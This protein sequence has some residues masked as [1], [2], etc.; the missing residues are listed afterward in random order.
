MDQY[1][2]IIIGGGPAGLACGLYLAR[3]RMK[4]LLIEEVGLGG[5][6]V[7]TDEIENYPGFPS[8]IKGNE[9]TEKLKE[10]AEKF[11]LV[12]DYGKVKEIK[13]N[14]KS[15]EAATNQKKREALSVI[16]ATGAKPKKLDI[17]GEDEFRG[18]GVSYCAT[19]DGAFF[20]DK[21]IVVVGGGDTAVEEAL[22]L[23][24]FGKKV[25]LIHRRNRLR[26]AKVLQERAQAND[27]IE[28]VW[29]SIPLQ[30]LG[31]Q[32]V[33]AVKIK[34]VKT[35]KESEISCQGI[36]VFVGLI[37]N[38][39]FLGGLVELDERGYVITDDE[40][41]TSREGVFACGDCRKKLLRQVVTA[42]GD[43]AVAAFSSQ[44]YAEELKGTAY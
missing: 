4:T 19:C 10:Q 16:I 8:G 27:K 28:F 6:A 44:K 31:N 21:D 5:Q 40:M 13:K 35:G 12:I 2:V 7:L 23:T 42:C 20:R 43:G 36:F 33:E 41:K 34:N 18:K 22:F 1:D 9:L 25:I 17:P 3:A 24:R 14:L 38:T 11:G 30:I 15:W 37:P 32:Q 29:D 39:D 26:A